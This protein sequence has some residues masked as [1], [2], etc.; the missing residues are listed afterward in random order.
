MISE[1]PA[2]LTIRLSPAQRQSWR[3]YADSREA[4]EYAIATHKHSRRIRSYAYSR[5]AK[6]FME[7]SNFKYS[8]KISGCEIGAETYGRKHVVPQ[9]RIK[10]ETRY[11]HI[12]IYKFIYIWKYFSR[13]HII[14]Y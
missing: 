4:L 11:I 6:K 10:E 7:V 3:L 9:T 14:V 2:Y 13:L 8:A 5:C 12:F 1:I